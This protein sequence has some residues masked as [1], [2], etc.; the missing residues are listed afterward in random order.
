MGTVMTLTKDQ[1]MMVTAYEQMAD[2]GSIPAKMKMIYE[3]D[4]AQKLF[5]VLSIFTDTVS[6]STI[7]PWLHVPAKS[8]PAALSKLTCKAP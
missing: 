4:C 1:V 3:I 7:R 6:D 8:P 2:E 5:R